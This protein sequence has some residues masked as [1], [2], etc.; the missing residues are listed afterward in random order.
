MRF[1]E[2][3]RRVSIVVWA[4]GAFAFFSY[5]SGRADEGKEILQGIAVAMG[6]SAIYWLLASVIRWVADGF[7]DDPLRGNQHD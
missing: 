2:G 3:M 4:I 1:R 7:R 6:F 5:G